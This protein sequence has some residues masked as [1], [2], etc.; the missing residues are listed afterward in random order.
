[1]RSKR[2]DQARNLAILAAALTVG[3]GA[4]LDPR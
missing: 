2:W 3:P 4:T 1:M